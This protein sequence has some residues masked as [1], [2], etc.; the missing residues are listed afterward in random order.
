MLGLLLDAAVIIGIIY[1]V[2]QGDQ[3]DFGPA[4][5]SALIIAVGNFACMLLLG[6]AL[7]EYSRSLQCWASRSWR[8]G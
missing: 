3:M 8:S 2:N 5:F 1:L 4:V 7:G 6:E